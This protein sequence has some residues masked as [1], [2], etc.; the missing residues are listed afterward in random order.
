MGTHE[1]PR[2]RQCSMWSQTGGV[3]HGG[4][5]IRATGKRKQH[6][7]MYSC[8]TAVTPLPAHWSYCSLVLSHRIKTPII[9]YRK[10]SKPRDLCW[11]FSNQCEIGFVKFQLEMDVFRTI[12]WVRDF[13]RSFPKTSFLIIKRHQIFTINYIIDWMRTNFLKCDDKAVIITD[14]WVSSNCA[15]LWLLEY[16]YDISNIISLF[17]GYTCD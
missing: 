10:F 17:L 14:G 1:L 7:A 2:C 8:K 12:Y 16:C 15:L 5:F 11:E 3:C 9:G 13:A 4:A 6:M